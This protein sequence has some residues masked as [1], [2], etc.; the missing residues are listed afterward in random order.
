MN[1]DRT[2]LHHAFLVME[3]SLF[4]QLQH[5]S[6]MKN[7]EMLTRPVNDL[8]PPLAHACLYHEH[9]YVFDT[10]I[11]HNKELIVKL[12]KGSPDIDESILQ[13]MLGDKGSEVFRYRRRYNYTQRIVHLLKR[14]N[15]QERFDAVRFTGKNNMSPMLLAC[16]NGQHA[17]LYENLVETFNDDQ[18]VE[19]F[20]AGAE[21][22][23]S[24]LQKCLEMDSK[25]KADKVL[26]SIQSPP[27]RF[28]LMTL[29]TSQGNS[30]FQQLVH[31]FLKMTQL[32]K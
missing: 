21:T 31:N 30:V 3:S 2:L 16:K 7:L 1:G 25:Y 4:E 32:K 22:N 24:L 28:K 15:N 9:T 13:F 11:N 10:A 20:T 29:S 18:I 8:A 14:L 5:K 17:K 12:L 19:L 6:G 26:K 27:L 23:N